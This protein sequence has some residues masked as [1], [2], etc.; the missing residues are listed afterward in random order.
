[1]SPLL[2]AHG[3]SKH[4]AGVAALVDVDLEVNAGEIV[5]LIGPN[6]SG[7]STFFN[8]VT[9]FLRASSGTVIWKGEDVT[10]NSA[11][12]RARKGLVRTFQER[13]CFDDLTVRENLQFPLIQAKSRGNSD[14]RIAEVME[15][16]GLPQRTLTQRA[17]ELS[18]GQTRLLGMAVALLFTPEVVLF[19]EPFA[20]LNRIAA[21]DVCA[22]LLRLRA[23]GITAVVVEHE[24]QLLL[25]LCD[26]VVV[27]ARGQ[28]IAEGTSADILEREEV[29][30]AYFGAA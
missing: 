2:E 23:E 10:R 18:W 12:R 29:R 28:K 21:E 27:M 8:V 1:M 30:L 9:G 11:H 7:K 4:F 14:A 19:D 16:V 26:R 6:G 3:L 15:W 25:P 5:G 17:S 20:G 22:A 24:M 13:M